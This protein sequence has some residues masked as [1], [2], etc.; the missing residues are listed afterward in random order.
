M[1]I[2]V[3]KPSNSYSPKTGIQTNFA[4]HDISRFVTYYE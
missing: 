2:L 1:K 4:I 3:A